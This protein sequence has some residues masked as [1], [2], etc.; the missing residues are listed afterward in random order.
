MEKEL[1]KDQRKQYP[2]VKQNQDGAS[3]HH[4]GSKICNSQDFEQSTLKDQLWISL[5]LNAILDHKTR[6]N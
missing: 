1:Q 5:H 6:Q 3:S 4:A 2:L